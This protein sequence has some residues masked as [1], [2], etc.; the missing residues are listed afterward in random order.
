MLSLWQMNAFLPSTTHLLCGYKKLAQQDKQSVELILQS[1]AI[2][3]PK[4]SEQQDD[5]IIERCQM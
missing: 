1:R 4:K 2:K 3:P 5:I